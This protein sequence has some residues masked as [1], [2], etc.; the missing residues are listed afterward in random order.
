MRNKISFQKQQNADNSDL[1]INALSEMSAPDTDFSNVLRRNDGMSFDVL[2]PTTKLTVPPG[3]G[4]VGGRKKRK[5]PGG[6]GSETAFTSTSS[7]PSMTHTIPSLGSYQP[8]LN[9]GGSG[10]GSKSMQF[11]EY[12]KSEEDKK[13]HYTLSFTVRF[14][15]SADTV[16]LSYFY[17]FSYSDLQGFLNILSMSP[18]TSSPCNIFRRQL[19]CRTRLGNRVDL[20]TV[21]N[22]NSTASVM[23]DR[24]VVILSARVHP[25]EVNAS[26]LMKGVLDFLLS[27]NSV[28]AELRNK[29]V[30]K[31]IPCLNPDGVIC[32][33]HRCSLS[34]VDLNRQYLRFHDPLT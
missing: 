25:G 20:L 12:N 2:V 11:R 10:S 6:N 14:P 15:Y 21:T 9:G 8:A 27:K 23:R 32:G 22:L 7:M 5:I 28:A 19:L 29:F 18:V 4:L 3:G 31:V 33:N 13:Y 1:S 26:W 17:P 34:G 24:P 16:F 30:F